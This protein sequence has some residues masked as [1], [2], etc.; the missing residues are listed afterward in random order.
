MTS[1]A[2]SIEITFQ[3]RAPREVV[4]IRHKIKVM[5]TKNLDF[6]TASDRIFLLQ[7]RKFF[8]LINAHHPELCAFVPEIPEITLK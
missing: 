2:F 6:I 5:R 8:K 3:L 1:V 7:F 4:N